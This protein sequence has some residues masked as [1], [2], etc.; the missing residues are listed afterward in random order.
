MNPSVKPEKESY[1]LLKW[2]YILG[3]PC[4]FFNNPMQ[5]AASLMNGVSTM[6]INIKR[7][8]F[9]FFQG[10]G[11]WGRGETCYSGS[12]VH[13]GVGSGGGMG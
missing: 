5:K 11:A 9:L 3:I 6:V 1:Q 12:D 7:T 10:G 4:I 13:L 2:V 8:Y